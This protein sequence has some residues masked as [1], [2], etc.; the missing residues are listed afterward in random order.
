MAS[1]RYSGDIHRLLTQD[2]VITDKI[3]QDIQQG[4]GAATSQ[5]P[6]RLHIYDP[7][8]RLM[9]EIHNMEN[10]ISGSDKQDKIIMRNNGMKLFIS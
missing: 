7:R 5:I 1:D 10:D 2:K 3:D 8:K 9:E 4:I 6:E